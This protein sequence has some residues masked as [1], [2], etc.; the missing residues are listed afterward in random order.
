MKETQIGL[1]IYLTN[2]LQPPYYRFKNM[3]CHILKFES[4]DINVQPIFMRPENIKKLAQ[5]LRYDHSGPF[6]KFT[7][8]LLNCPANV[9]NNTITE[10]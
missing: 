5:M 3:Q 2:S 7:I 8:F 9:T 1:Y 4:V 10:K 6:C